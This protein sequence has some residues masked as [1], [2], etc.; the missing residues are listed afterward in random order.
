[1]IKQGSVCVYDNKYNYLYDL[2]ESSWFG[3]YNIMFGVYSSLIYKGKS[4]TKS[5]GKNKVVNKSFRNVLYKIPSYN[6]MTIV[7]TDVQAFKHFH[8]MSL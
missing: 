3:E 6:F 7:T 5:N 2:E 8:E 1:M 4:I